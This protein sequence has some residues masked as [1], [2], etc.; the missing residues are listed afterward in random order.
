MDDSPLC[1]SCREPLPPGAKFCPSCG[2]ALTLGSEPEER[3][4]VTV[5]FADLEGFTALAEQRDPESVKA[6]L[7]TCFGHLVP[8]ID[9]H[10]GHIDKIIGDE[11]MA[12][13][14]APQAHD[15]D[16]ER[17]VHAALGLHH[18]LRDVDARLRLRVG[19][20]TGEVLAGAVG[21]GTGYTVTGDVVNTA[22]RLATAAA[23]GGVLVG[24]RTQQAAASSV[25]F[26]FRGH[27][28]LKGKQEPVPAWT[29]LGPVE[30][31]ATHLRM[32]RLPIVG[33]ARESAE[34][35]ERLTRSHRERRPE[36]V[37]VVGSPGVGKTRLATEVAERLVNTQPGTKVVWITCPPYGPGGDLAPLGDLVRGALDLGAPR[38]RSVAATRLE[39][40]AAEVAASTGTD[41]GIL[42][43]HLAT[44]VGTEPAP[45]RDREVEAGW[46]RAGLTDQQL[47]AVRTVL[48][49]VSASRPVLVVVDDLHWAGSALLRFLAHLPERLGTSQVAV[50]AL[51]RSDLLEHSADL[52]A[53][54]PGR[55]IQTLDPLPDDEMAA[56]ALVLLRAHGRG[57]ARLGPQASERLVDAAEGNPLVLEQLV[58]YLV[59]AGALERLDDLW[60]LAPSGDDGFG[61]ALPDGVRSLIGARLDA[62]PADERLVIGAAAV[63]GTEFWTDAVAVLTGVEDLAA[64]MARL[65]QKGIVEAAN[66]PSSADHRFRHVLTRD[67]AY[68]AVPIGDR[69]IR[70]ARFARWLEEHPERQDDP[71]TISL[72][73]HHYERAVVLA[74][75]I[76]QTDAGLATSAFAALLRAARDENRREGLRRADH[77]YRRAR[78]L[79]GPAPDLLEALAE[80]GQVLLELRHLDA[81]RDTFEELQARAADQPAR[82]A[83]AMGH[84]AAT[85]RLGGDLDLADERFEAA[86]RLARELAD[87]HTQAELARLEG[88]TDLAVGRFRAALPR[89]ER[90]AALEARHGLDDRRSE[91]LRNLGWCQYLAGDLRAARDHLVEA[92]EREGADDQPG[93]VAWSAGLLAA[94]WLHGGQARRSVAITSELRGVSRAN[95]DPWGEWTC[96]TLEAAGR[97]ALGDTGIARATALEAISHFEELDD[98]WGLA[99][100]R[101]V[102]AQAARAE[103]DLTSAGQLLAEALAAAD[104]A[105]GEDARILAELA[106]VELESDQLEEAER[107]ARSSLALV[108]AGVGD[109]ESG[110]RALGVL[111]EAARQRDEPEVAELLLEEAVDDRHPEDRSDAWRLAALSL[112]RLR[113]TAG[114][115]ARAQVLVGRCAESP[116]DDVSIQAEVAALQAQLPAI[117]EADGE[118]NR[119]SR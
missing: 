119:L 91:T 77:W 57:P 61:D 42:R 29:A 56:L 95:G 100:A 72:L 118:T 10:G 99:L 36:V 44:I 28:D 31:R 48:A 49:H 110:L 7:D 53:G 30:Q 59:E 74:R 117:G 35:L 75:S 82:M 45:R 66:A 19:V 27:L 70:H 16:P 50:L 52:V 2:H 111:A 83:W 39:L 12:V 60:Q 89:L 21:P 64:I 5:L 103:G 41:P 90:A 80:H 94:T 6:F 9:E 86:A 68:A 109:H 84:L 87:V 40:A 32:P 62:L 51:A 88:W 73:A 54:G 11:L 63:V 92:M 3:R 112:A 1:P 107:H 23:P 20:N 22:H 4:I 47:G 14:G 13:F 43:T 97:V 85:T 69:A 114:D 115:P 78:D 55:S 102:A 105:V 98:A 101:V 116:T 38:R 79:G 24:E 81:A 108:R 18:A 37:T 15:D 46:G 71:A 34:I 17:A 26:Q 106:R 113:L 104:P 67:V 25:D 96:A 8:V 76:D 33:R 65:R 58:E 93:V